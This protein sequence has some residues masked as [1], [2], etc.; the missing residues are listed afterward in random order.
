M[1]PNAALVRLRAFRMYVQL[2]VQLLFC[3]RCAPLATAGAR[4]P[5]GYRL[6]YAIPAGFAATEHLCT[7][8]HPTMLT[9]RVQREQSFIEATVAEAGSGGGEGWRCHMQ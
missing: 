1:W 2:Y 7:L 5:Y 9:L 3:C 8:A 6:G 4:T